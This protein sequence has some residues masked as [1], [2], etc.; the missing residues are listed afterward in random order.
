MFTYSVLFKFFTSFKGK[1]APSRSRKSKHLL[2][3]NCTKV[4]PKRRNDL[5]LVKSRVDTSNSVVGWVTYST[6]TKGFASVLLKE[7]FMVMLVLAVWFRLVA[8]L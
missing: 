5:V 2:S 6:E 3:R 4:K 8:A 7:L 1:P